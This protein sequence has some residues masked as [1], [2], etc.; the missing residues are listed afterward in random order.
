MSDQPQMNQRECH[1]MMAVEL[2]NMALEI[3]FKKGERKHSDIERMVNAAHG[4]RY[5]YGEVGG[6]LDWARGEWLLSRVYTEV[7]RPIPAI[8]YGRRCVDVC[9]ERNLGPFPT[10][11]GFEALTRVAAFLGDENAY[12]EYHQLAKDYG[13]QI[14]ESAKKQFFDDLDE[15]VLRKVEEN[16]DGD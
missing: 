2:S 3:L 14:D 6:P 4:S 9:L 11:Y 12:E 16:S 5:H 10:A 8:Y 7:Q 13:E 1:L 15:I